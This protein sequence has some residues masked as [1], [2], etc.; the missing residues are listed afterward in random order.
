MKKY[1]MLS[2]LMLVFTQVDGGFAHVTNGVSPEARCSLVL[3]ASTVG[4]TGQVPNMT[5]YSQKIAKFYVQRL[6]SD[7]QQLVEDWYR[8]D[9][10]QESAQTIQT[11]FTGQ[12]TWYYD[13]SGN[14]GSGKR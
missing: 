13:E 4:L 10:R 3:I 6:V 9:G 12:L 5:G 1:I 14:G 8:F 11:L 7:G 2:A